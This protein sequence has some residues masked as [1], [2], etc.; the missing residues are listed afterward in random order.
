MVGLPYEDKSKV[1]DTIKLNVDIK[2]DHSLSP[3]YYPYPDTA[4]FD[5]A[6]DEG[7]VPPC[8][9]YREDRYVDQSSLPR[10]QLYFARYYFRTFVR[11]YRALERVPNPPSG[12]IENMVD[13]IFISKHL[14]HKALVSVARGS[15]T[16]RNKAKEQLSRRM[17]GLYLWVR[18]RVRGV[19]RN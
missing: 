4:L 8:Y 13:K 14:P 9:D 19:E 18:D 2:A 16:A 10:E 6:V 11:I 15:E 17:P 12:Y 3:I 1:L 5:T 7:W